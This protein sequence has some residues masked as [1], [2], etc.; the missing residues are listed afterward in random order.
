MDTCIYALYDPE[1]ERFGVG[2]L[3]FQK[4]VNGLFYDGQTKKLLH[5]QPSPYLAEMKRR[6]RHVS[7]QHYPKN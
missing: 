1:A 5:P 6:G 7:K 3:V 2:K 4:K